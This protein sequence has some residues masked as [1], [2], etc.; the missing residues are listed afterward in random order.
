[1]AKGFIGNITAEKYNAW[2]RMTPSE[3]KELARKIAAEKKEKERI[4]KEADDQYWRDFRDRAQ[5]QSGGDNATISGTPMYD[6]RGQSELG[7]EGQSN[8][9]ASGSDVTGYEEEGGGI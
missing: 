4:E 9:G 1:M 5:F 6:Y 8:I 2:L 7:E 3:R